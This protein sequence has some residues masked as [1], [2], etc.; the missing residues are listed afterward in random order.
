M[1]RDDALAADPEVASLL[2]QELDRQQ[3]TLQ[4]IASENFT[5]PAVLAASGLRPDQQV[6]R[7][8]SRPPLLR[9]EPDHRRGRGPGPGAGQGPVRRRARQRAAAR[10]G[11]RQPRGLPGPARAR[12]RPSWPCGST[13]GAISPMVRRHRIVSKFWRFVSYGV[14]P[15]SPDDRRAPGEV[16]DFDQVAR[17]GQDGEAGA[18]RGRLDRVRPDDRPPALPRDR[19]LGRG[20]ASCSTPHTR[21]ASLP[22]APTRTRWGS[23][24]S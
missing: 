12:R 20:T 7:G 24:T 15:E 14:T 11:Q 18:H 22:G 8:L 5:S 10:R 17:L 9:R 21:P 3:T 23:P 4:L 6:L 2:A 1:S 19:R 16:I 13:T